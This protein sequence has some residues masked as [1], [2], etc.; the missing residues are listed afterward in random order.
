M[1]GLKACLLLICALASIGSIIA[2]I[3]EFH[4]RSS[5]V[6][7]V[8]ELP[9]IG[10]VFTGQFDRVELILK[11][12]DQGDL[13][14]VFISGVNHGAGLTQEGFADKFQLSEDAR[15]ALAAGDIILAPK[16]TTTIENALEAACWLNRYQDLHQVL[17]ITGRMHMPRASWAL[18]RALNKPTI[19]RRISPPDPNVS[20]DQKHWV[21]S[22]FFKFAATAVLTALPNRLWPG[23]GKVI[24]Q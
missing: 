24:C 17:L 2:L 18:E 1:R 8:P 4:I 10:V 5:P 3:N 9:S 23:Q 12:F 11:L 7:D 19:V 20:F 15:A 14:H 21:S 16:A 13:N 6:T 22:E